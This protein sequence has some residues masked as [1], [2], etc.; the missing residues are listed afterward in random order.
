[1]RHVSMM[2]VSMSRTNERSKEQGNS[3]S[4]ICFYHNQDKIE[5]KTDALDQELLHT[6]TLYL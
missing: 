6:K 5:L 2:H 1:M 4:W 3:L